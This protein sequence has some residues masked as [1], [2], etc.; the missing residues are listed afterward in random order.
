[1]IQAGTQSVPEGIPTR[2]VGTRATGDGFDQETVRGERFVL[3][4]HRIGRARTSGPSNSRFRRR[5]HKL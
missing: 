1:M 4:I 3:A 5:P 2:S